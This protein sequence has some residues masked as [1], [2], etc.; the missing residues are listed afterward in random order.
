M[1]VVP[2]VYWRR[3]VPASFPYAPA[4]TALALSVLLGFPAGLSSYAEGLANAAK[5]GNSIGPTRILNVPAL[6]VQANVVKAVWI[7]TKEQRP[8]S[9]FGA[10]D[11]RCA[12]LLGR[13]SSTIYLLL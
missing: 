3:N 8:V 6:D 11:T 13:T 4:A 7:G 1:L 10:A 5:A 9:L 2:V 12:L